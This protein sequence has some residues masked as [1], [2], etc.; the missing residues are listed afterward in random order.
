MTHMQL[1]TN[2][3]AVLG[4]VF[5]RA[6]PSSDSDCLLW[7]GASTGGR[8]PYGVIRIDGAKVLV[9]RLVA[10]GTRGLLEH[11]HRTV[12]AMHLCDVSLCV[13]PFHLDIGTYADNNVD[14]Y[15][16]GRHA[17]VHLT[18]YSNGMAKIT[19][20]VV[21]AIRTEHAGPVFVSMGQLARKYSLSH[22][23]VSDI[24][25]RRRWAHIE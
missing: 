4:R 3:P 8:Q 18:G 2:W 21:K 1:V 14:G 23:H 10:F 12:V 11:E 17:P 15:R 5:D 20:D 7:P 6:I 19:E 22:Q 16:K 9:H 24:I 13:N 25:N